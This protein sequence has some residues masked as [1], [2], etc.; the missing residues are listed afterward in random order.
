MGI[1]RKGRRGEI[2]RKEITWNLTVGFHPNLFLAFEESPNSIF[3]GKKEKRKKWRAIRETR[4]KVKSNPRRDDKKG[5][6]IPYHFRWT[7]VLGING[8]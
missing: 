5:E 3:C 7:K 6:A 4:K 2:K 8:N 1:R